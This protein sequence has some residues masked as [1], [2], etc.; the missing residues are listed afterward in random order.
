MGNLSTL[1]GKTRLLRYPPARRS[2]F[3]KITMPFTQKRSTIL[4][5]FIFYKNN[6]TQFLH[7]SFQNHLLF[8][9]QLYRSCFVLSFFFGISFLF[10]LFGICIFTS[11]FVLFSREKVAEFLTLSFYKIFNLLFIAPR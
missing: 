2:L 11:V 10:T 1:S 8:R 6:K 9:C 5:F 7:I 3:L 4:T